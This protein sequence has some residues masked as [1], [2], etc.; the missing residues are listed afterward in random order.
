MVQPFGL[1]KEEG[2]IYSRIGPHPHKLHIVRFKIV[3]QNRQGFK[4]LAN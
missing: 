4:L 2:L 1:I 3:E